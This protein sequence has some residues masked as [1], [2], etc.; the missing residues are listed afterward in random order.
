MLRKS[1]IIAIMICGLNLVCS[2]YAY[3]QTAV[4]SDTGDSFAET[5]INQLAEQGMIHGITVNQFGPRLKISRLQFATLIA[6]VLGVQPLFPAPATFTDL[7]PGTIE[8]GYVE[9]LA[10]LGIINGAEG[11]RFCGDKPISREAAAVILHRALGEAEEARSENKYQDMRAISTYAVSGVAW[12]SAEGL[13]S[14]SRGYFFPANNLTRE[15][16]AILAGRLLKL[17]LDQATKAAPPLENLMDLGDGESKQ[18]SDRKITYPAMF[19]PVYGM[20]SPCFTI[21]TSSNLLRGLN[22]GTGTL[23]RNYGKCNYTQ[24]VKVADSASG[25]G[26]TA[27]MPSTSESKL[28]L[29]YQV[30]AQSPDNSFRQ[31]EYKNYS[32]PVEGLTSTSQTWTGFLRQQGREIIVDLGRL[33]PIDSFSLEFKQDVGA[34]IYYP[35]YLAGSVSPDGLSWY[36]LGRASHQVDPHDK[37]VQ[38]MTLSLVFPAVNVRYIKMSLPVDVL[39]F[40]RHLTVNGN[41]SATESVVLVPEI[42]SGPAQEDYLRTTAFKDLLLIFTGDQTEIKTLDSDDFLPLVT[43]VN[44]EGKVAGHMFD[45]IQFMPYTGMPCSQASWAAYLDDLFTPGRQLPALEAA[46]IKS[47]FI[48]KEKVVLSLPYPDYMQSDFGDLGR[49]GEPLSL[50]PD[51]NNRQA[52]IRNR[53]AA[54][55]WYYDEMMQRWNNAGFEHLELAGIY[56]YKESMD[57]K[58]DGE[59]ELLQSIA[60]MVKAKGQNFIWIPY[61]G[62]NGVENWRSYGFTHVFLQPNYYATQDPPG[63]R[64]DQAAALARKYNTGIELELDNRVLSTRYYY[65][66]FYSELN[67]AHEQ[68]LD[69]NIPNAYYVGFAQ[70]LLDTVKSEVP[71]IRKV[72]DDLYRWINEKYE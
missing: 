12:V 56:W 27:G 29:K 63:D 42:G 23:T 53:V 4:F 8:T 43:Y 33:Q 55:Q 26:I 72:Y 25:T 59:V 9:A 58:I 21:N 18:L 65:D 3:G 64:M 67:K 30:I 10:R 54:V 15:E 39:V 47:G 19:S 6:R 46:M 61:Y 24:T 68:G 71:Q 37:T 32:G 62:A 22:S 38:N 60:R 7:I 1:V 13:M 70:T 20:D 5:S 44:S 11:K 45:T 49:M 51:P 17:R 48:T 2:G 28:V 16:A 52:N 40:A 36:E 66:L 41:I 57:P 50:I 34:G 35:Q 14:G 69:G 31:V